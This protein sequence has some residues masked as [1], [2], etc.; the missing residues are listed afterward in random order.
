MRDADAA[1]QRILGEAAQIFLEIFRRGIEPS[2][3]P[4]NERIFGGQIEPPLIIFENR[5]CFD[6]EAA[7]NAMRCRKLFQI[8]GQ[9]R[10][11]KRVVS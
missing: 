8:R 1:V 4:D 7:D 11:R 9:D 6:D 3:D 5:T 2:D 10:S